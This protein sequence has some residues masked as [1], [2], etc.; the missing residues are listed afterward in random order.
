MHSTSIPM[1]GG[2][3]RREGDRWRR[4]R[5]ARRRLCYDSE[6]IRVGRL[7]AKFQV[8]APLGYGREQLFYRFCIERDF[9]WRCARREKSSSRS[10]TL[11]LFPPKT[12]SSCETWGSK[13]DSIR[14]SD[15]GSH[16]EAARIEKVNRVWIF[17]MRK[18]ILKPKFC[19]RIEFGAETFKL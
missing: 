18:L 15:A 17:G 11:P 4:S 10:R 1:V 9:H 19:P 14:R 8:S 6:D 2:E 16:F 5:P 3:G 13:R 12:N 7:V